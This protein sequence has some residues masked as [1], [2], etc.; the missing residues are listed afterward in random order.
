MNQIIDYDTLT[1]AIEHKTDV[2][3]SAAEQAALQVLNFF[4]YSSTALD[5]YLY[6]KERDLFYI[7]EDEGFLRCRSDDLL[8]YTGTNWRVFTWELVVDKILASALK[9]PEGFHVSEKSVYD[10]LPEEVWQR[11]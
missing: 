8:L 1:K 6:Q 11:G 3:M 7:L 9:E 5:N 4:G 10:D 2:S